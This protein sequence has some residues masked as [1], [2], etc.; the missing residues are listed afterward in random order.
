V[1][2]FLQQVIKEGTLEMGLL[3]WWPE[4]LGNRV[5]HYNSFILEVLVLSVIISVCRFF[6]LIRK[7]GQF[8]DHVAALIYMNLQI[9]HY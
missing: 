9:F 5:D 8:S 7:T 1:Q 4:S 6:Q 3:I 2:E